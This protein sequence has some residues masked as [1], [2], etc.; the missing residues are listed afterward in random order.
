MFSKN[1]NNFEIRLRNAEGIPVLQLGGTINA[2]AV[3]AIKSTLQRLAKAGH[4]H[5][6][7]NIERVQTSGLQFLADLSDAV[8]S[9]RAH[10]GAVDVVAGPVIMTQLLQMETVTK[11]YR[12]CKSETHA[13][14][15]IKRLQ[16]QPDK[17]STT[18]ARLLEQR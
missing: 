5:V 11:L 6:V 13:I 15:R 10:Y 12:L 1:N 3:R 18:N 17:V 2:T 4:Y 16:R 7:L 9:I 14:S 8:H